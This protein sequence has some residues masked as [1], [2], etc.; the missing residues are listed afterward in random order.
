MPSSSTLPPCPYI[1]PH[2]SHVYR[3]SARIAPEVTPGGRR[4]RRV[5]PQL[6]RPPIAQS[7]TRNPLRESLQPDLRIRNTP[8]SPRPFPNLL[9]HLALDG[10]VRR[11]VLQNRVDL[12]HSLDELLDGFRD[13]ALER[14]RLRDP[15]LLQVVRRRLRREEREQ[16]VDAVLDA[17]SARVPT[18]EEIALT[19]G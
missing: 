7:G 16:A 15:E 14:V 5:L 4:H 2:S 9:K 11:P 6:Q 10:L 1:H 3:R 18:Q 19:A 12:L 8:L 13:R 17:I